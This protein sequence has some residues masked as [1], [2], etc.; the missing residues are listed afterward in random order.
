MTHQ[1]HRLLFSIVLGSAFNASLFGQ[2]PTSAEVDKDQIAAALQLTQQAATKYEFILDGTS[3]EQPKLLSEPI[4]RWSNPAA[5]QV[6]G[7]VFLWTSGGRPA[8]VGSLF[9]W[10]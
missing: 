10:F 3:T 2:S 1:R 6:H 4:L 9:K 7:N 5:G 8:V